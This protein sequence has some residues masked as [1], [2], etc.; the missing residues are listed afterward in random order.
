[1]NESTNQNY[2]RERILSNPGNPNRM[3]SET[4]LKPFGGSGGI[5]S[6]FFS[7]TIGT[8]GSDNAGDIIAAEAADTVP[9]MGNPGFLPC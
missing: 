5:K 4:L 1:M 9:K 8:A 7:G 6:I 3:I 2:L